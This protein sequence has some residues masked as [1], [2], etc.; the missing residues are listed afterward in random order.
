MGERLVLER[1]T[2]PPGELA[3]DK[4]DGASNGR[5]RIS[6]K[7][8][9]FIGSEENS[10]SKTKQNAVT[11]MFYLGI[12]IG[13]KKHVASMLAEGTKKPLFK[14][15][16]FAN[17]AEG[18][19][20]LTARISEITQDAHEV[21]IGM[22][23][24]GHYWLALYSFLHDKGYAI[25]VI[26]P[27]Q[28]DGW[29]KGVEI[30]KRKTDDIDSIL[31]ADL[32]RY[33]DFTETLLA[34]EDIQSLRTLTRFRS[35]LVDSI[36][37][38]KRKVICVLDQVFPEY[39]TLFSDTFG[40]TSREL[41]IQ[42]SSPA[43]LENLSVDALTAFLEKAS[44]S[45]CGE[46]KAQQLL[47]AAKHSFGVTHCRDTFSFQLR[48]LL[49][50]MRFIEKQVSDT[51]A[52][53]AAIMEKLDSPITTI[54]G[55]GSVLGAVI[56][57]EIGDIHRFESPSKLVAYAGID[58]T[59]AQSGEFEA[60]HNRMSKRGSPYLRRALFVASN[61]AVRFD[62]DLGAFYQRKLAEGKHHST[63]LGAVSRKLCYIIHAILTDNRPYVRH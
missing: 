48:A 52:E 33:G 15:F 39:E 2:P 3:T 8:V 26:N 11:I 44:R 28:T 17:T 50:Q 29:R 56:L 6:H 14:A 18:A 38:L 55:I 36:S 62:P 31:I 9:A 13:K 4:L 30:R 20:Q 12:D 43:D 54:P 35:Y 10:R 37:D 59:V 51:E 49:E 58:A 34:G 63:C 25:H 45:K 24:T 40:A 27:I 60:S 7:A 42:Y 5:L 19:E 23:A 21:T 57:G 32:I 47:D 46:T 16:S 41:L 1:L 22:E 61:V 53:I